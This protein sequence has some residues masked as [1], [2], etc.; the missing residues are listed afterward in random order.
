[1]T[2]SLIDRLPPV[3]GEEGVV[4]ELRKEA[5]AGVRR[6]LGSDDFHDGRRKA[7]EEGRRGGRERRKEVVREEDDEPRATTV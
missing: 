1:M 7:L 5:A 4:L 3:R 2:S 6:G